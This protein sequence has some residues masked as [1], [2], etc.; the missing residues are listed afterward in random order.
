MSKSRYMVV[1]E[2]APRKVEQSPIMIHMPM[3]TCSYA[4]W[5]RIGTYNPDWELIK[6]HA[7]G[8]AHGTLER[9]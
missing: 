4:A 3:R 6:A 7:H 5:A 9:A 8:E 2:Q 1:F